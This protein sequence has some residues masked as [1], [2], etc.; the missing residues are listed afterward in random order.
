MAVLRLPPTLM[1]P[2]AQACRR[3]LVQAMA[4][5]QDRVF[6]LDASP[7]EQFDSSALAVL[8]ACRREAFELGRQMQVQ[9]LSVRLQALARLYGVLDWLQPQDT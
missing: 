8:L 4:V 1:H 7:L 5:S 3:E 6:L 2:Q 9:G